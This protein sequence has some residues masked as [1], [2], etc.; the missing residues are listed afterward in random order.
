[1]KNLARRSFVLG[2][3]CCAFG[4]HSNISASAAELFDL[5]CGINETELYALRMADRL[6]TRDYIKSI[7]LESS[8]NREFDQV[9]GHVLVEIAQDFDVYPEFYFFDDGGIQQA[10]ASNSKLDDRS[11]GTVLF[12]KTMLENALSLEGG[13]AAII[14]VCAHEYA[15]IAAFKRATLIHEASRNKPRYVRELHADFISGYFMAKHSDRFP[16]INLSAAGTV[17]LGLG[18]KD[19]SRPGSHGTVE[20]RRKAINAGFFLL[21]K[22]KFMNF[23]AAFSAASKYIRDL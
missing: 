23:E 16:D 9:L 11:D 8:G 12:G 21:E 17:W 13:D 1:M 15:H 7:L 18:S 14:A 10:R 6:R 4:F 20:M 2:A 3:T 22:N 5:G 19:P